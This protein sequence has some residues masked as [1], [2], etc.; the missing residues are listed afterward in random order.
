MKT[1]I[2]S[3]Y[4]LFEIHVINSGFPLSQ[5]LDFDDFKDKILIAVI[6][7][8]LGVSSVTRMHDIRFLRLGM[9]IFQVKDYDHVHAFSFHMYKN[10][11]TTPVL[12]DSIHMDYKQYSCLS[13]V[14]EDSRF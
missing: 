10:S 5:V 2:V 11:Q 13:D 12:R 9:Q 4:M 1:G 7:H 6:F 8:A 3:R 14:G